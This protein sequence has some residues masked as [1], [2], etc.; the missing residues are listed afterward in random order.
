MV[1]S[2]NP[3]NL[4]LSPRLE[5]QIA[6]ILPSAFLFPTPL[7]RQL[8]L[9]RFMIARNPMHLAQPSITYQRLLAVA[10]WAFGT[11]GPY[12]GFHVAILRCHT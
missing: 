8:D 4:I 11:V 2:A 9:V 3:K 7:R 6:L 10:C 5:V 12:F 1:V